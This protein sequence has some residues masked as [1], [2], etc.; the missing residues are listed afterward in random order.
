MQPCTFLAG[1]A[2]GAFGGILAAVVLWAAS[3]LSSR[4]AAPETTIDEEGEPQ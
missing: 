3:A 1:V 2:L 4:H